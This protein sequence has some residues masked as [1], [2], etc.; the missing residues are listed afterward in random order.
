MT[1]TTSP[2]FTDLL[3]TARAAALVGDTLR[4]RR[5]FRNATEIDPMSVEAWLGF[6]ATAAVL[7]ERRGL[8]ERALAIDPGCADAHESI[9]QID[10]LL[11]TGALIRPRAAQAAP[12]VA[13]VEYV[14]MAPPL[15]SLIIPLPA[16][17]APSRGRHL[18]LLAVAVI[19]V[20]TMGLLT[21]MGIFVLTS[22]WGFLL[23]FMAGPSVSELMLWLTDRVR[24][25]L[26]GRPLQIAAALGMIVGGLGAMALGGLLLQATG[27]P[28][29]AEAVA[30]ARTL[31]AGREPV[32]VLLNS[33]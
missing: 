22:F 15:A 21:A 19:G 26:G 32:A 29:P 7:R 10:A 23:A 13:E 2:A 9:A 30:M 16:V 27:V 4:A 1:T 33:P 8:Y 11:A 28:L 6:A 5:Y 25:G 18:G 14:S 12:V 31:G 24:K 3:E 17:R 20:A